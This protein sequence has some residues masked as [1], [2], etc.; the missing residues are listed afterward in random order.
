[1]AKKGYSA[2]PKAPE[3]LEPH[4]QIVL[5]H[6]QDI[7]GSVLPLCRGAVSVFYS[8]SRLGKIRF[9]IF[10]IVWAL[11][12]MQKGSSRIWTPLT[13]TTSYNCY[14]SPQTPSKSWCM[15]IF[16]DHPTPVCQNAV[17]HERISFMSSFCFTISV[18]HVL[19]VL[20]GWFVRWERSGRKAAV[21]W[22]AASMFRSKLHMIFFRSVVYPN[23]FNFSL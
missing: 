20:L 11:C 7:H 10:P 16:G 23:F 15:Y 22:G 2:L 3:L 17:I 9:I 12:K 4:H 5:C 14:L 1:M 21:L 13:K 6:I 18:Q 19:F 8:P